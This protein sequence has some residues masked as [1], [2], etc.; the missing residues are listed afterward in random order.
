M[1]QVTLVTLG[2]VKKQKKSP[3]CVD[4]PKAAKARVMLIEMCRLS[5]AVSWRFLQ[6]NSM[7]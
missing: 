3:I 4:F 5:L 7:M 2:G 6:N 1:S